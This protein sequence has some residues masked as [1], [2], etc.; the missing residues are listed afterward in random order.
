MQRRVLTTAALLTALVLAAG[1]GAQELALIALPPPQT[2]G[3]KPLM[4]ALKLRST[5]RAFAPDPLPPQ[6]LS[7]LLW[8]AWGINRPDGRRTAP[9]AHNWQEVDVYVLL[10]SGAYVYDAKANALAPIAR[11][12]LRALGGVQDFVKEA[13]LTL[14]LVADG[15]KIQGAGADKQAIAWADAAF[16]SENVYLFCASEGLATGVRAMIDRPALAKALRLREGQ[17][18]ALAQSVGQFKRP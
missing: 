8:A 1:A 12:D 10:A 6:T 2:D 4:Q 3:G 18:V 14:V 13:P 16:V 7:N 15:D 11:G 9:S 17:M 5:S